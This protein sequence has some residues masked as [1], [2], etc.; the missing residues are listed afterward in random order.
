MFCCAG[1]H[2]S[3]KSSLTSTTTSHREN[4]CPVSMASALP[5]LSPDSGMWDFLSCSLSHHQLED[6]DAELR[7]L[8]SEVCRSL[9]K[10]GSLPDVAEGS[11][12]GRNKKLLFLVPQRSWRH[13]HFES[14]SSKT[15]RTFLQGLNVSWHPGTVSLFRRWL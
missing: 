9:Y 15:I 14:H 7:D 11:G 10:F 4:A 3:S 1:L 12:K 8:C 6:Y 5:S 13:G 2:G